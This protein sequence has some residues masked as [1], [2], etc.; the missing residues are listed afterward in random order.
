M[1]VSVV[2]PTSNSLLDCFGGC[3]GRNGCYQLAGDYDIWGFISS[4]SWL[5]TNIRMLETPSE[6]ESLNMP[7]FRFEGFLWSRCHLGIHGC[8][9]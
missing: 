6:S 9:S 1:K 8:T 2:G 5:R 3:A 4:P 7:I